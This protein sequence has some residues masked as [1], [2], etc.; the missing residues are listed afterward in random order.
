MN[1]VEVT[2]SKI[3]CTSC[4]EPALL[5]YAESEG[6]WPREL[7]FK[8]KNGHRIQ[9]TQMSDP[10]LMPP[11]PPTDRTLPR[12]YLF[13][14]PSLAGK[15]ELYWASGNLRRKIGRK[16]K[17]AHSYLNTLEDYI[18]AAIVEFFRI[19]TLGELQHKELI[20]EFGKAFSLTQQ[21]AR[22]DSFS[23]MSLRFI[24]LH[25]Y[26]IAT[27]KVM[28]HLDRFN[29][30]VSS[31]AIK[32][33]PN[34]RARKKAVARKL[35]EATLG[36]KAAR[37]YLEHMEKE[38]LSGNFDGLRFKEEAGDFFFIYVS[39]NGEQSINLN[40]NKLTEAYEAFIDLMHDL[41]DIDDYR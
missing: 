17:T 9:M 12:T 4:G 39:G 15:V 14:H 1:S 25:N 36:H 32:G 33:L 30:E 38:I 29:A 35:K 8:C 6:K 34:W 26:L 2:P 40:V 21:L 20:S 31:I 22:P 11:A 5:E 3:E 19:R 16:L 24:E 7:S 27:D 10:R 28:K 23:L 41:P 18:N 13:S 37:N